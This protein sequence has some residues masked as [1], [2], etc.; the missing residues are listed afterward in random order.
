MTPEIKHY[1]NLAECSRDTAQFVIDQAR[2]AV[3]EKGIFTLVMAGGQTP[4]LL[5]EMLAKAP[6]QDQMPWQRT[7]L[8]WTDERLVP[9]THAQS[10]YG[11]VVA[12]LLSKISMPAANVHPMSTALADPLAAA[13]AHE[14]ELL[15]FF[16]PLYADCNRFAVGNFV[17]PTPT[18][19][20]DIHAVK[21]LIQ[22]SRVR[23]H[24]GI[25]PRFDLILLGIGVDGHTASLFPDSP[26]LAIEDRLVVPVEYKHALP[27]VSRLTMTL[28]VLNNGR[29][30]LFLAAGREKLKIFNEI[31]ANPTK[32]AQ[33]YP[34]ARVHP[35]SG[36]LIWHLADN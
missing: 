23:Q 33:R 14:E 26:S 32:A 5:Y 6:L 2:D 36:R 30:I 17:T 11:M 3:R 20:S 27:S 22:H 16:S 24:P 12:T 13:V 19:D 34:A 10:N 7:H 29:C 28:P 18:G 31:M 1:Q 4:R 21:G 15:D 25:P 8:F 9:P 35:S